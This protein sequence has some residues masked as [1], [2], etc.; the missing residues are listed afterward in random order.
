MLA[1]VLWVTEYCLHGWRVGAWGLRSSVW[2]NAEERGESVLED[3]SLNAGNTKKVNLA[4][5]LA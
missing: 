2:I 1:G 5:K 4:I 3:D